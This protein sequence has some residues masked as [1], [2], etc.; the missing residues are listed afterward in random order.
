[1]SMKTRSALT[2][3]VVYIHS[4]PSSLCPHI[5]WAIEAVFEQQ[6]DIGWTTQP[7]GRHLVRM[8][9][10]WS[11]PAGTGAH[12]ASALRRFRTIRFEV[13]EEPS[14]GI[15]GS[16]WAYTPSLGVHHT[17]VST[18]GDVL[19]SENRLRAALS[20]GGHAMVRREIEI[21]LGE[22]WDREL[23]PFRHAGD[24]GSVRWLHRVG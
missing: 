18:T 10:S 13:V 14:D 8:E 4:T 17:I 15:D 20:S 12:L 24:T 16:R 11:A 3:G 2:Q 23:E 6:V 5:G 22:P 9:L 7:L 21:A 19:V 1:M